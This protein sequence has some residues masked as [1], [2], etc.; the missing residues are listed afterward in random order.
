MLAYSIFVVLGF[1]VKL[2]LLFEVWKFMNLSWFGPLEVLATR[3]VAPYEMPLWQVTS[4]LNAGLAWAYFFRAQRYLLARDTTEAAP[5]TRIEREYVAFQVVRT[6]F[7][8]YAIACT[9]YIA[10][11]TAWQTRWPPIHFI[12]FPRI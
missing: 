12:L 6:T 1:V 10:A 9:L 8:L 5:E 4:A 2:G 3:L 7:S 11:A